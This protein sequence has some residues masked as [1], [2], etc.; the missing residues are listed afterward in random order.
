MQFRRRRVVVTGVGAATPLGLNWGEFRQSLASGQ[1]G[2][3]P[4][5]LCDPATLPVHFG[6]EVLG[7]DAR[8]FIE[9]KD[10]KHLKMMARTSHFAVAG[11][12]LALD[13]AGVARAQVDPERFGVALGIAIIPGELAD[14]GPPALACYDAATRRIDLRRWGREGQSAM[15]PMWML[16]HVPNMPACHISI[17]HDARGPNNTIT[18]SDAASLLAVGEGTRILERDGADLMLV[19]GADTRSNPITIV[20][21]FLFGHLSTRNEQPERASRP[22]DRQRDGQVLGE[23]AG[24]LALEELQHARRRGARIRAELLGFASGFDRGCQGP[25]LARVAR[26]ALERAG[27]SPADLDHVNAHGLGTV[28]EDAWE[29]RGIAE[30]LAGADVPVVGFKSY[31]GNIGTGAG[32]AELAASLA[33]FESGVVP[34]TLNHD[35]TGP[36]CPVNVLREP[37]PLRRPSVLKLSCTERGQ[38][39]AAVLRKWEG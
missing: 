33:A 8:D 10:R 6:G 26:L 2:I 32:V 22:F 5:Q 14:L 4:L 30:A 34:A 9:K 11:V 28:R 7:F 29:A 36:D 39:A 37:R 25:G 20:R 31:L 23:G 21:Y 27:L 16:N 13:D 18:Q 24:V 15:P 3:R 17:L 35:E 19:G 12:R 1:G 38:C